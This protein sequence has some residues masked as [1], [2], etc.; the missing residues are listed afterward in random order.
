MRRLL[1]LSAPIYTLQLLIEFDSSKELMHDEKNIK[2]RGSGFVCF[3]T[4]VHEAKKAVNGLHCI[5]IFNY[6]WPCLL[7]LER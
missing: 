1:R 4:P 2:A 6:V 7:P 3:S 5:Y